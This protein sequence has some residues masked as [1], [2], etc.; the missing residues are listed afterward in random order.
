[1][2]EQTH[3]KKKMIKKLFTF[4]LILFNIFGFSQVLTYVGNSALVTVQSQ[5]LVYNGGGLQ[6][7]GTAIVNNSGNI[8]IN[9]GSSDQLNIAATSNFNLK[10]NG[11]TS[12][13]QL[14]ISGIT[15]ANITGKVNKEYRADA[16][17]GSTAKQQVALPFYNYPISDLVS[18]LA[19]S[20]SNTAGS[21]LNVTNAANNSA[22][23]FN[24]S[25]VFRWNNARARFDQ[26]AAGSSALSTTY[27]GTPLDY[28]I[29]PRRNASGTVVWDAAAASVVTTFSGTPV[30]D[31]S[32]NQSYTLSGAAAGIS[33]GYNGSAA[34]YYG[35]RY[36][37]YLDDPFQSKTGNAGGW[38]TNYGKNLYQVANPFLTNIDLRYIGQSESA[39]PDGNAIPNL[40][41]IAYYTSGLTWTRAAGTGY[42]NENTN[43]SANGTAGRT[44][45][46][47]ASSGVFQAGD[48][49][50]GRLIIKPMGE[51][52]VKLSADNGNNS[53]SAINYTLLRRFASTSRDNT[54]QTTNPTSKILDDT[55]IP[56]DKIVKQVAV[57]MY[58]TDSLEIDRTYYAISPS[59]VTGNNPGN[60][61]LQAYTGDNAFVYTKEEIMA[62][63][64]D[65][66]LSGKL[67]INEA[68]EVTYKSKEIPLYIAD[69]GA[70]Y[71][72]KFEVYEKGER[73]PEGL[74]NGN[75]FYIKNQ[76]GQFIKIV[77]GE[78]LSMSG[79]QVL[80]LFYELPDGATLAT[81]NALKGQ[82]I[83]GKKDSQWVVR[84]A[85]YWNNATV[86]VYSAAGQ[87]LN[88][89]KQI[90]T[91]SDYSIPLN[92]QVKGVFLVKAISDRGE[93]V[94]KKIVN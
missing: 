72:L 87:L 91:S 73:V 32:G 14:Y 28:Y 24:P 10:F 3:K 8:M 25:S 70:P 17:S 66:N 34:N 37:S 23:R 16:N 52:M 15:Q 4:K 89:K 94:T 26:I 78:S 63:G 2:Q 82:T 61:S 84:F 80:G 64:E 68:N 30:S 42:P 40:Q 71:Y 65:I 92:Y 67:Y 18:N 45:V 53:A 19:N 9:A 1:M 13:G 39:N 49:S 88:S 51:F 44:V 43:G 6:T 41:G 27:V 93:V 77:D 36:Y 85:K 21:Y 58:D 11:A 50:G 5:T 90:S 59:A 33:F 38:D 57:I 60:T 35:E 7:A 75:S 74:S 55:D 54:T 48:I 86:E 83:I 62:G 31:V 81:G 56:T 79:N 22:G 12:Y 47:V 69:A 76:S 29:L 46:M 20:P